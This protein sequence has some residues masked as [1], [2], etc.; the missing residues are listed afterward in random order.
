[1]NLRPAAAKPSI[2]IPCL[3]TDTSKERVRAVI[4]KH[5]LGEIERVDMVSKFAA[6]TPHKRAFVH[7]VAWANSEHAKDVRQRLTEGDYVNIIH[8]FPWFWRCH[9]SSLPKPKRRYV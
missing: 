2:C 4:E 6:R 9:Q 5:Q 7:F 1:M 3:D 8:R